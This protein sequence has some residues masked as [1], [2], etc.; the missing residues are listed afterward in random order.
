MKNFKY[1]GSWW[2]PH[3]EKQV[4]GDLIFS[5]E[6]GLRLDLHDSLAEGGSFLDTL[7]D[8]RRTAYPVVL[9]MTEDG[10]LVTLCDCQ[11]TRV[12][13]AFKNIEEGG[14]LYT[15]A[16]YDARAAFI[17][18]HFF[19]TQQMQFHRAEVQYDYLPDFVR[20]QGFTPDFKMEDGILQKYQLTYEYPPRIVATTSRG[21]ISVSYNFHQHGGPMKE[22]TLWQSTALEIKLEKELTLKK[23]D[24]E[25][26]RPLQDLM[27]LAANRPTSITDLLVYSKEKVETVM[28]RTSEVPIAV[29]FQ[30]NY[31]KERQDSLLPPNKLLFTLEDRS[32]S[33]R[34]SEIIERW[35]TNTDLDELGDVFTLF[36]SVLYAPD[37]SQEM[38]FLNIAFAAELYHRKRFSNE[39]LPKNKHKARVTSV[40]DSAPEEHREW[41]KN[42]L[43]FSNEPRFRDRI[44]DLVDMTKEVIS[45][46]FSDKDYFVNKVRDT[47]HYR[48][49]NVSRLK[50]N[51]AEGEELYWITKTLSY[52]VQACLLIELGLTSQ[53]CFELFSKNRDYE[54]ARERAPIYGPH[55]TG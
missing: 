40:V 32:V 44:D 4:T 37:L 36:F 24:I 52:L 17:G 34:F 27:S 8:D 38:G 45:P 31:Q 7:R 20:K 29:V 14:F 28:N 26:I 50:K 30:Q 11:E 3:S 1:S 18:A 41:V 43:S 51:A 49:H 12:S 16:G 19:E 25:Y 10:K 33:E 23:L 6:A 5:N 48:V 9:G 46:L 47:R 54:F 21:I 22:L 55:A 35:L 2:L 53:D 15:T 42:A 39:V 13:T